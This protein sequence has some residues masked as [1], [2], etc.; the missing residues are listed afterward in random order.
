MTIFQGVHVSLVTPMS[1]S[2][3]V[4]YQRTE[5]VCD[6]LIREGVNGIIVA[7]PVGEYATLSREERA[8][9]VETVI[10]VS[11]GR[12]PIIAGTGTPT[13][14]ET[15]YW[16][17]HA[18]DKGADGILALPPINYKPLESEVIAHYEK[19]SSVGIPMMIF[20]NPRDF[21]IDL[22]PEFLVDLA[23]LEN[24]IAIKEF[25]G[26]VRRIHEIST[27]TT[28]DVLVGVDDMSMEGALCGATG[29]TSGVAN[30]LPKLSVE[31][32][33]FALE[34]DRKEASKLYEVLEP[35]YRYDA[36]P[37]LIQA[38]KYMMELANQPVGPT[39]PPRLP[40]TSKDYNM[41]RN[42]FEKVPV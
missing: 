21:G 28:L 9:I 20:N 7:G 13:T 22:T 35:L 38:I 16:A 36:S 40:L 10:K 12:V 31:L 1:E 19:L 8:K 27:K 2:Y 6:W 3:E 11:N 14:A 23:K 42:L 41:I 17:E 24:I 15:I 32:F 25:S 29:W 34:N 4:D 37:Q 30:A 39:R 18:L 5:E 33:Q 26:D